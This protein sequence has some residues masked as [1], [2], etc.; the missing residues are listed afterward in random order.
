MLAV[1]VCVTVTVFAATP[2]TYVVA[3]FVAPLAFVAVNRQTDVL[4]TPVIV[5]LSVVAAVTAIVR[6]PRSTHR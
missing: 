3:M 1:A 2:E 4:V 6:Q 5:T